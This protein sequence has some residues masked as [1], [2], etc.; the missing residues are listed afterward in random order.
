MS[1]SAPSSSC[2]SSL[3]P[4]VGAAV[5]AAIV[6]SAPGC[7]FR[8]TM[9]RTSV[10]SNV[11]ID[12]GGA[13]GVATLTRDQYEVGDTTSGKDKTTRVF[14]LWFPV[15]N[16]KSASE[17][18]DTAYANAVDHAKDCDGLLLPRT[19]VKRVV[20]PLLLVNVI[21]K[22]VQVQGRCLRIKDD[23]ALA[24][25]RH[26]GKHGPHHGKHGPH[27]VEHGPHHGEHGSGHAGQAPGHRGHPSGKTTDATP[28][29]AAAPGKAR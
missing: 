6:F 10:Q 14:V 15:G 4:R 13:G 28:A 27:R 24:R 18:W 12:Q 29:P 21:V 19:R 3:G 25:S 1:T 9:Q 23:A 11:E 20:V 7:A 8:R 17:V 16:H 5:L 2:P 26:H 22:K